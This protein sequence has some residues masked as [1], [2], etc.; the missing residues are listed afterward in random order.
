MAIRILQTLDF[1]DLLIKT[2]NKES[3][4]FIYSEN[5]YT[6]TKKLFELIKE[7]GCIYGYDTQNGYYISP[8]HIYFKQ[9]KNKLLYEYQHIIGYR[10]LCYLN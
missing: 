2:E 9:I 7:A 3:F 8:D 1:S 6:P 10:F 4:Y 5:R